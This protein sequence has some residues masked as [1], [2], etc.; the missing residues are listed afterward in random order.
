MKN[1]KYIITGLVLCLTA[2]ANAANSDTEDEGIKIGNL[3][4]ATRN[5]DAPGT[6]T[7]KPEDAGML[8]QWNRTVGWSS[9]DPLVNSNGDTVWNSALYYQSEWSKT[10]TNNVCPEGWRIPTQGETN[11]TLP[12]LGVTRSLDELNGINGLFVGKDNG[13]KLFFPAAGLRIGSGGVSDQA[14]IAGNYWVS[15]HNFNYTDPNWASNDAMRW[16]FSN[17]TNSSYYIGNRRMIDA[18][19]I[20]CVKDAPEDTGIAEGGE[21][22][23]LPVAFYSIMGEPLQDEPA[24]GI[25]IVTY[26]NGVVEKVVKN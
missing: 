1:L 11:F 4:W 24:S 17:M 10:W 15:T 19:S 20:R 16:G 7:E 14:G 22:Q 21:I 3:I 12:E 23:S 2:G 9:S 13:E 8:Y 6:F 5:V 25:Y 26:D 18:M